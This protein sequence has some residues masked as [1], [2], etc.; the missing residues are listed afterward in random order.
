M[1]MTVSWSHI[2]LAAASER[3]A[4]YSLALAQ[5][6]STC[7]LYDRPASSCS[8][9]EEQRRLPGNV[10]QGAGRPDPPLPSSSP[11]PFPRMSDTA[12][13]RCPG[14]PSREHPAQHAAHRTGGRPPGCGRSPDRSGRGRKVLRASSYLQPGSKLFTPARTMGPLQP[15][16]V[17]TAPPHPRPA[18]LAATRVIEEHR[19]Q[20][21]IESPVK[22]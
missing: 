3:R 16:A 9:Q 15:E 14:S 4:Q 22:A 17:M 10:S 7:I 18:V 21:G 8:S 13:S 19:K 12:S 6:A 20:S 1:G 11:N 5:S 2:R